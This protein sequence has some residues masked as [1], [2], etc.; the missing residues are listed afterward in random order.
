MMDLYIIFQSDKGRC[1]GNQIM[2]PNKGKLILSAFFAHSP[3]VRMVLFCYYLLGGDTAVLSG[4][5]ARLCHLFLV[6]FYYEQRYLS[7][8][9]TDFHDFFH[10]M[11]GTCVNF[12]DPFQFFRFLKGHCHGNQFCVLLSLGAKVYQDTLDRFSQSLHHMVGIEL[13][14]INPN[15]FF[16][17]IKGRCHGNQFSGK[18]TYPPPA[19][20]TLVFRHKMGYRYIN[21]RINSVNDASISCTNFV[22]W[23]SNSR[24]NGAHLWTFCTTWQNTGV[25]SW[26]SQDVLDQFLRSF[27]HIKCFEC[28]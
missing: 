12:L 18:I 3:D 8:Y 7:I 14:M 26:I 10:Q 24:E 23:S 9:W 1:H 21:V 22:N 5:Y 2:L 16:R 19:L 13:Q 27:H 6:F 15:F 20:I 28:R 11:E 25:F 4:L 17:Y